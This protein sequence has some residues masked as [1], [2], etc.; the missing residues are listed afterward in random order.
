M[1]DERALLEKRIF[2]ADLEIQDAKCK[3]SRTNLA[4]DILEAR[5]KE[6]SNQI[7]SFK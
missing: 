4:L 2:E 6:C 7:E 3:L 5:L 1:A